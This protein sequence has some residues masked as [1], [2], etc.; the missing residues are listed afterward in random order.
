MNDPIAAGNL[1]GTLEDLPPSNLHAFRRPID[2]VDVEIV[3]PKGVGHPSR[4]GDD[5][6]NCLSPDGEPLVRSERTDVSLCLLP[7]EKLAVEC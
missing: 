7:A 3:K 2:I 4:L 1:N 6:T 5:A